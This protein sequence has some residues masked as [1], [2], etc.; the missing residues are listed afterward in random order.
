MVIRGR[1]CD[2]RVRMS[3]NERALPRMPLCVHVLHGRLSC[4]RYGRGQ[5]V[6]KLMPR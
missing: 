6:R 4:A 3:R 5:A 2:E 1:D